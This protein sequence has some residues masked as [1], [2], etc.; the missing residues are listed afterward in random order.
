MGIFE[1]FSKFLESRL[2]EFLQSN[3][4]LQLEVLLDELR[5]Q[6][7]DTIKLILKLQAEQKKLETEIIALGKEIQ[8]W[9][10]RIE[11]ARAS[12]RLDLAQEAENREINLLRQGKL[13]WGQM[14]E[15]KAKIHKSRDL[16]TSIEGKQKELQTKMAEM[17]KNYANSYSNKYYNSTNPSYSYSSDSLDPLD[18]KFRQWEIDQELKDMKNR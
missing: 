18:E 11:K 6:E 17:K 9:H 2:E 3:P 10:P 1:D 4:Q 15:T 16:L 14:E 7:K 5:E 13:L 12:G 8:K